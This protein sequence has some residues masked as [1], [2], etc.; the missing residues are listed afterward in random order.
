MK[1]RN[2]VLVILAVLVLIFFF[3]PPITQK[4]TYTLDQAASKWA[5]GKFG[6]VDGSRIYYVE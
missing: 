4:E 3:L 1:K 6:R 2:I 5:K